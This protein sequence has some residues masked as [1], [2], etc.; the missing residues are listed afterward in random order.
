MA[1]RDLDQMGL[2]CGDLSIQDSEEF[3]GDDWRLEVNRM[4]V[5]NLGTNKVF[6]VSTVEPLP[7]RLSKGQEMEGVF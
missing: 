4:I 3:K 6:D 2:N 1:T 5:I 7:E